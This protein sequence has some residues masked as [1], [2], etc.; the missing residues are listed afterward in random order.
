MANPDVAVSSRVRS[1]TASAR[2]VLCPAVP[3]LLGA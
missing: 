3:V 2:I 1:S